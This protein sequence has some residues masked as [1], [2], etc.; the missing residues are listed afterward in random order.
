MQ[1]NKNATSEHEQQQ[2]RHAMQ[3]SNEQLEK[4]HHDYNQMVEQNDQLEQAIHDYSSQ[5]NLLETKLF[6]TMTLVDLRNK[7]LMDYEEQTDKLKLE[8]IQK[9][10]DALDKQAHIDEL[11]QI[12][13]EKTGEA[14][15]LTETLETGLV[16][17]HHR[18]KFAEDNATKAMSDIKVLQR[19]VN[20][21]EPCGDEE[22]ILSRSG[23]SSVRSIDESRT[24]ECCSQW[25]TTKTKQRIPSETRRI[26]TSTKGVK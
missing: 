8:L 4:L 5:N 22:T 18:E 1:Q 17:S 7:T 6:E 11:E 23:A 25:R 24:N 10:K 13:I 26:P 16:K 19:E 20:A 21:E 2:L 15:Q 3:M 12:V 14:A 9:H